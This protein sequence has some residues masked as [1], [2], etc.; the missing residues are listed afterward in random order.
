MIH[1]LIRGGARNCDQ[2]RTLDVTTGAADPT[3]PTMLTMTPKI[4]VGLPK[5]LFAIGT[6]HRIYPT[7]PIPKLRTV[8]RGRAAYP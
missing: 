3:I 5:R 8:C 4:A 6:H 1:T 2:P 7:D